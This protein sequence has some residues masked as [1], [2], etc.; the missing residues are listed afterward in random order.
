MVI[1]FDNYGPV[2]N[3]SVK[4]H[5][6]EDIETESMTIDT[7]GSGMAVFSTDNAT[8]KGRCHL[9]FCVDSVT[10]PTLVYNAGDN[11][12]TCDSNY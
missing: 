6:Q 5:F 3:A 10:H 2:L 4:G 1:I 12:E 8:T 7:D 9:T 11:V